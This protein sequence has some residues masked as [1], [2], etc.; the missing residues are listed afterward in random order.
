MN[1]YMPTIRKATLEDL[2]DI[3]NIIKNNLDVPELSVQPSQHDQLIPFI[4][5][6]QYYVAVDDNHIVGAMSL[7]IG[8]QSCEI[9][10]IAS[11][12]PGCG[13]LL[14]KHA[15]ALCKEQHIPKIWCW[16]FER[17]HAQGFYKKMGFE[18]SLLM[19]KQWFGEDCYIF[20]KVIR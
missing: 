12:Q 20:G 8:E 13:R 5:R 3:S 2:V 10:T 16:S 9:Y 1:F 4:D 17:Y 6:G 18:E 19:R 11:Q 15:E 7:V 14:V